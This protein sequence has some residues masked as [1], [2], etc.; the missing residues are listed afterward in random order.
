MMWGKHGQWFIISNTLSIFGYQIKYNN[1][2]N[3][4]RF[5]VNWENY[6]FSKAG[7]FH[8]MLL[9][10]LIGFKK[11]VDVTYSENV[12]M[13]CLTGNVYRVKIWKA[14]PI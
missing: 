7:L 12:A 14:R 13:K 5:K 4:K 11:R 1:A 2:V 3:V 10:P 8:K 6:F 9:L